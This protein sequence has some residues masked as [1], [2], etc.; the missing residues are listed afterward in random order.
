VGGAWETE[1]VGVSL[2]IVTCL[3]RVRE[4]IVATTS[5]T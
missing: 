3:S 2:S 1:L 4:A 5:K